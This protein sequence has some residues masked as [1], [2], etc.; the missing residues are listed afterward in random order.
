MITLFNFWNKKILFLYC[1]GFTDEELEFFEIHFE[2]PCIFRGSFEFE[3]DARGP[4]GYFPPKSFEQQNRFKSKI[5]YKYI[6]H[7]TKF[8]SWILWMYFFILRKQ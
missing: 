5:L 3:Q 7:G 2:T 4:A 6:S 8:V 1:A